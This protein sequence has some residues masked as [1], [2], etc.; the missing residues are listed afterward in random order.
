MSSGIPPGTDPVQALVA[1]GFSPKDAKAF[2]D[3]HAHELAEKQRAFLRHQMSYDPNEE[4]CPCGG[5][6]WC[7]AKDYIDLTDPYAKD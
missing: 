5:C 2:T 3:W 4:P 1:L 7:L 6:S